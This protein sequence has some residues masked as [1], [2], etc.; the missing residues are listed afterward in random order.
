VLLNRQ[1]PVDSIEPSERAA[2]IKTS[3]DILSGVEHTN[4]SILRY[5]LKP[6]AYRF[7]F[8]EQPNRFCTLSYPWLGDASAKVTISASPYDD[9]SILK[10]FLPIYQKSAL[11]CHIQRWVN[12]PGFLGRLFRNTSTTANQTPVRRLHHR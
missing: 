4:R 8:I 10:Q 3:A 12:V 7:S 2:Q 11:R 6:Q 5:I 9:K 1:A